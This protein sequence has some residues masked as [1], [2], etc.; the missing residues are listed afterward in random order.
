MGPPR[1]SA[2]SASGV[3]FI[4]VFEQGCVPMAVT[5]VDGSFVE[6]NQLF[7]HFSGYS[8]DELRE[9]SMFSLTHPEDMQRTFG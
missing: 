6:C 2:V 8:L 4:S 1:P 3:D 5:A 9:R 7:V